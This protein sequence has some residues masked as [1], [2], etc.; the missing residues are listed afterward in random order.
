MHYLIVLLITCSFFMGH[1]QAA[2][3]PTNPTT[4][5]TSEQKKGTVLLAILARNKA[6]VLNEYLKT[7]ENLD[8][9]KKCI[10]IYINTN[11]NCDQTKEILLQWMEK[12]KPLYANI[13]FESVEFDNLTSTNPH[14]WTPVRFHAL[15]T[16]RNRSLQ[17]T[18]EF[19]CDYYFVI[20]CDNFITPPTLKA[21]I[22]HDKPIVAPMLLPIPQQNEMYSNY[23]CAVSPSGYYQTHPDYAQIR[24]RAKTGIFEVPVV[25]CTYLIKAEYLDR[26]NYMDNTD[27]YEF[28]I[29][30][31]IARSNHVDQYICNDLDY[32]TLL[33]VPGNLTLNEE[34]ACFKEYIDTQTSEKK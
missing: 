19:H 31:R 24:Y 26:L 9:D 13:D 2:E 12:N 18:K 23:F 16:I 29:F 22:A 7:I 32:G 25:H 28:V 10:S 33:R 4:E 17:K 6:H 34:A 21:L 5:T 11:N 20:D 3:A 30:S 8:Y 1:V 15:A 14:D 27:D